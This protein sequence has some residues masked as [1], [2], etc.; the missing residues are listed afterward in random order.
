MLEDQRLRILHICK[1]Y[2]PTNGGIQRV[3]QSIASL[4]SQYCHEVLTT[5]TDRTSTSKENNDIQVTRCKAYTEI[6]A[7]PIAPKMIPHA[8]SI[9]KECALTCIHY[10]FPLADLALFLSTKPSKVIVFWHSNIVAQTRLKW[11]VFPLTY[12]TLKRADAIVTTSKYMIQNSWTLKHFQEKVEIIPFGIPEIKPKPL[13]KRLGKHSFKSNSYFVIVGRHVP[14][15]G[16]D[17]AIRALQNTNNQLVIVGAGPLLYEHKELAK[18]AN[19]HD[20]I[21]FINDASNDEVASIIQQ[22]IALVLPSIM[23]NEAFGLVQLE[24]MRLKKP[25]INTNLRSSVP[26]IARDQQEGITIHPNDEEALRRAMTEVASNQQWAI[27]LGENGY[28]RFK[29]HFTD[30]HFEVSINSMFDTILRKEDSGK[31]KKRPV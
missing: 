22:S 15:K 11:L 17:V 30:K 10:P 18:K 16:I 4:S 9:M 14:Y 12:L 7:M 29:K 19:T 21:R 20:Q 13:S 1:V 31:Q 5:S 25:V 2:L 28:R 24:A 26:F 8:I 23:H 6:S 3:V 27:T